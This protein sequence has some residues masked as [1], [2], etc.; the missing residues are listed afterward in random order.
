MVLKNIGTKNNPNW[1]LSVRYK[2]KRIRKNCCSKRDA[3][4][5][6]ESEKIRIDGIHSRPIVLDD[7]E[8]KD[9]VINITL[10]EAI[11]R[12]Y[13]TVTIQ[14][15]KASH[16]MEKH[17]FNLLFKFLY[18]KLDLNLLRQVRLDHIE[19]FQVELSK[20]VSGSTINRRFCLYKHFFK[21][22]LRWGLIKSNPT[23]GICRVQENPKERLTWTLEE[24]NLILA[25][26]PELAKQQM[27][28][29]FYTAARPIEV[30]HLKWE[31]VSFVNNTIKLSCNK[32]TGKKRN[33]F[34]P[35]SN[36]VI[37]LMKRRQLE[38]Q[39]KKSSD[40][41]FCNSE[42]K[43]VEE[44]YLCT[45][46]YRVRKKLKIDRALSPYGLRHAYLT[47]LAVNNINIEK[48]RLIAGHANIRT[49]QRYLHINNEQLADVINLASE[50]RKLA[51]N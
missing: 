10:K 47:D 18:N 4:D 44:E 25:E 8:K 34:F 12:Y 2:H 21:K 43:A 7:E 11:Q 9:E 30:I 28:F 23:E 27:T 42:G 39:F 20:K 29:I 5:Y 19:Q 24:T 1:L 6:F 48:I 38:S 37:Q 32:G 41:V 36:E 15:S 13:N 45:A 40:Y 35:M 17:Y 31:D 46:V 50:R 33:R 51:I 22:C 49:T 16:S 3:L 26:L 14:K